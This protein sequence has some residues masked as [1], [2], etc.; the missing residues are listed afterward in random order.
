M[1]DAGA[2]AAIIYN[3]ERGNFRG[4]LGGRSQIPAISLS[5]IDGRKIKEFFGPGR[6][7]G[8]HR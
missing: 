7:S 8:G 4:T 2:V 1:H 6:A 5:Q 3:N